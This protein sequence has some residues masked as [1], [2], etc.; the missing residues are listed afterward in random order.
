MALGAFNDNFLRQ[1]LIAM[2]AFGDL[3]LSDS[4][5]TVAGSLA[6]A[7]MILPFFLFSSLAGQ[8]ADRHPKSVMVR[9]TKLA[10][11]LVMVLAAALFI[12]GDWRAIFA[13]LFLMGAQSAFFGPMKYG[14][15]PEVLP[16]GDL[17]AGN[18]LVGGVSFILIVLGTTAGSFLVTL[19]MGRTLLVPAGLV[20][21]S[22]LGYLAARRQ[23]RSVQFDRSV[24]ADPR[25]WRSTWSVLASLEARRDLWRSVLAISWFWAMG[26]VL[27]TQMPVVAATRMG[28]TPAVGTALVTILALGVALGALSVHRLL[29]GRI[30]A[31]LVPVSALA[32]AAATLALAILVGTL[33]AAAPGSV[34]LSDLFGRPAHLAVAACCLLISALGGV[35]VVPLNAI[36]QNRAGAGE[37]ARVIAG[38]NIMNSLFMAA[39]NGLVALL[40]LNGVPLA[41][42]FALIAASALAVAVMAAPHL[43]QGVVKAIVRLLIRIMWR[44]RVTGLENMAGLA[45]GPVLIIP[46]HTS[47]A[48]VA[49]LV[50][51][52]PRR[53]TFAIDSF[54]AEVWWVRLLSG[55]FE[56]IPI[57]TLKPMSTRDL[58]DALGAGA[59]L[60]MFP[61]GRLTT[62]G[63]VMKVYDGPA[64]VA[65]HR[66]VPL[67]PVVFRDLEYTRFGR[68]RSVVKAPPVRLEI[69][70]TVLPPA[71]LP[72]SQMVGESRRDFRRRA[73]SELYELMA[74]AQ[75]RSREIP[76]CRLDV[77]SAVRRAARRFGPGRVVFKDAR[78]TALTY[79]QLLRMSKVLGRRLARL[80][81]PGERVGVMLPNSAP[82]AAALL[83]LWAGGR[84]P[85]M[86]NYSQGLGPG[87]SACRAAGV[88]T[89]V[90]S[91]AFLDA[92]GLRPMA[93]GLPTNLCVLE[94]LDISLSDKILGLAWR[95][96]PS[97]PDMAAVVVFTSGSEGRPKGVSLS[98]RNLLSDIWQARCLVELNEDD[99]MFNPMPAFHAFGLNIGLVLPLVSGMAQ[100]SYPTP[101][102]VKIIPELIYDS[103][104]TV[105]VGSDTFAAAWGRNAHPYDFHHVRLMILGAE[106]VKPA[107]RD[108]Y[109]HKLSVRLFEGYGVTEASPILAVGSPMFVRD[110][111]AGRMLP[112][113]ERRIEPVEGI[114][115]GGR[116]MV[117]GPNVMMGYL[118]EDEPGV[119]KAPP[120]GWHDTGDICELDD[121]GFLWIR[122]RWGRF[123]K[124]GGEM[125][126]LAAVEEAA[127]ELWPGV[128]MAVLAV[129]DEVRG[130]RLLLV[131]PP[132]VKADL[133][134]LR[135][136]IKARGLTDLSAPRAAVQVDEIPLSPLGKANIPALQEIV[137]AMLAGGSGGGS[138]GQAGADGPDGPDG[139]DVTPLPPL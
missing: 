25:L 36:L 31:S 52:L 89:V 49:L 115:A 102:H 107:T 60:V 24:K 71:R 80:A 94:D 47:F 130:E 16:P 59:A 30:S 117:R 129:P 91:R 95:P 39:A 100:F 82:L 131:H 122:G 72:S 103:K 7:L 14:L 23:P 135:Q 105:V 32:M 81:A 4:G 106:R 124:I 26:S 2:V 37:R 43:P 104:A 79:R 5:K 113:V 63:C 98:H 38:N 61:E 112:G 90:T 21:V 8:L 18:G 3:G 74:Q 9:H 40:A 132:G 50:A 88:K 97:S 137:D 119:V 114:A 84:V 19:P 12:T 45:D 57:N 6:T 13:V 73:S 42:I 44:P 29:R 64:A 11:L 108:L 96:R 86:L 139:P 92:A 136:R 93:E 67:L 22:F 127:F 138:R 134:L 1:A 46:N 20:L 75:F 41:A 70:M 120:G 133:D 51:Y 35:F 17:V 33:P 78:K 99:T 101:L 34:G 58:I 83:G 123:A 27:L 55:C 76:D 125:V 77:W 28:G 10:E 121:D 65:G 66:D 87:V 68:M 110:G 48:D 53:L 85:V 128:P 118:T 54:W 62:T 69:S 111:S 116:L 109:F 15:L 126:S 56:T